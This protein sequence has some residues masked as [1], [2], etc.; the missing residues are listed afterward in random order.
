MEM[1]AVK[2]SNIKAAG[3]DGGTLRVRFGTGTEYE[4]FKVKPEVFQEFMSAKSQGKYFNANIRG[5]YEG[6]KV[7]E[8]KNDKVQRP[9]GMRESD[10]DK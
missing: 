5:K 2:S 3:F 1:N 9:L 7:E 6:A 4:Y 8:E 10:R